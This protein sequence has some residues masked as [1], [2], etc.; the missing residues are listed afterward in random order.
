MIDIPDNVKQLFK[1]DSV[2]K[3]LRIHFPNGEH[4][5]INNDHI[6]QE[7]AKFTE[8]LCS[9]DS[10]KFGLCERSVFECDLHGIRDIKGSTIE[11]EIEIDVSSI[12]EYADDVFVLPNA[13]QTTYPWSRFNDPYD[14]TYVELQPRYAYT[15]YTP[16][17]ALYNI[18]NDMKYI[19]NPYTKSLYTLDNVYTYINPGTLKAGE[20]TMIYQQDEALMYRH[21]DSTSYRYQSY[22]ASELLP[23]ELYREHLSFLDRDIEVKSYNTGKDKYSYLAVKAT[24]KNE[25]GILTDEKY[26]MYYDNGIPLVNDKNQ[27][28][29][30]Q[31]GAL[32]FYNIKLNNVTSRE[33]ILA[34]ANI[35]KVKIYN[36]S[37]TYN[38]DDRYTFS[39]TYRCLGEVNT[40]VQTAYNYY[41]YNKY[42]Y[43][44]HA[45]LKSIGT[46]EPLLVTKNTC[47]NCSIYAETSGINVTSTLMIPMD[48]VDFVYEPVFE[49]E[50]LHN[51]S[52][53]N[54]IDTIVSDY[55][56]KE[57]G[58]LNPVASKNY[59]NSSSGLITY[60]GMFYAKFLDTNI[61]RR[62]NYT[63]TPGKNG[64][65]NI[66]TCQILSTN[67]GRDDLDYYDIDKVNL[68]IHPERKIYK[69][70][71]GSKFSNDLE[72]PYYPISYGR[73]KIEESE[74]D[75]S[76]KKR[77]ITAYTPDMVSEKVIPLERD[78]L[79][80]AT[81][82]KSSYI[83]NLIAFVCSQSY[84]D[85]EDLATFSQTYDFS[86]FTYVEKYKTYETRIYMS[87][88]TNNVWSDMRTEKYRFKLSYKPQSFDIPWIGSYTDPTTHVTTNTY[89]KNLRLK[90]RISGYKIDSTVSTGTQSQYLSL[91]RNH[92]YR[93]KTEPRALTSKFYKILDDIE[94]DA[95][96]IGDVIEKLAEIDGKTDT[97]YYGSDNLIR[98]AVF[99]R[100]VKNKIGTWDRL[101][102]EG[103]SNS[104]PFTRNGC[105][106][107]VNIKMSKGNSTSVVKGC[108]YPILYGSTYLF[109]NGKMNEKTW[110]EL[111]TPDIKNNTK[112][113]YICIPTKIEV[114]ISGYYVSRVIYNDS[115]YI[116]YWNNEEQILNESKWI[117]VFSVSTGLDDC[118]IDEFVITDEDDKKFVKKFDLPEKDEKPNYEE[119]ADIQK[120]AND[121]LELYGRFGH[122]D[123]SIGYY[124]AKYIEPE[125][126][127]EKL[128][129]DGGLYP[130]NW[131]PSYPMRG[132]HHFRKEEYSSI[133]LGD[134]IRPINAV[135]YTNHK[136]A[137]SESVESFD[138]KYPEIVS[139]NVDDTFTFLSIYDLKE[140]QNFDKLKQTGS[141]TSFKDPAKDLAIKVYKRIKD[142]GYKQVSLETMGRP[143]LE[144]GDIFTFEAIEEKLYNNTDLYPHTNGRNIGGNKYDKADWSSKEWKNLEHFIGY[145]VWTDGNNIYYSDGSSNYVLNK[146]NST[147]EAK[148]WNGLTNLNGNCIWTDGTNIY[149][150]YDTEQYVLDKSTSTW[151][152]KTWSGLTNFF[153]SD[154]WTDG[155]NI[156]YS[157]GSSQYVLNKSNSTWTTKTWN[158]YSSIYSNYIWTDG[159]DFYYSRGSN[160]Y[161]LN[162]NT[163]TWSTKVWT[164]ISSIYG[165]D[166]WNDG[167]NIYFSTSSEQYVL[168]KYTSTWT[169][170]IWTNL[171][172]P[173]ATYIWTDGTDFYY[174]YN[175]VQYV[176]NKRPD[177]E[178]VDPDLNEIE[179]DSV[180]YTSIVL[181]RTLSGIQHLR[182]S[183][184][185]K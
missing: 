126:F 148:T 123:R 114:F 168:D 47:K 162:R 143:Y 33:L 37:G 178:E 29:F 102:D 108:T 68:A 36:Q 8:S 43:T 34:Y 142:I 175:D 116:T 161:V 22:D 64:D 103:L 90:F 106:P 38:Y 52:L 92:I 25:Y 158:G 81:T 157:Y 146:T 104:K 50:V 115:G 166:I 100:C 127:T 91:D 129:P 177:E 21:L 125:Y 184:E 121:M 10:L 132:D 128:L 133:S 183:I 19:Y 83:P 179:I 164:G 87:N 40:S 73:F 109:G 120:L 144:S 2:K 180:G 181:R 151:T 131:G 117:P 32:L 86:R 84:I 58:I 150:S 65:T 139:N 54:K 5:D 149:Y 48:G 11:P 93:V 82:I 42:Y 70:P 1:R 45:Y 113:A 18:S 119:A 152:T 62:I 182:D 57:Y 44:R 122:W 101:M 176:Y 77:H 51:R 170:K 159:T 15:D 71:E 94:H 27:P 60:K 97:T 153:G 88:K 56:Y 154:I 46:E 118:R 163:D 35:L 59:E 172:D 107:F 111:A 75:D 13:Y 9:R 130:Y 28:T 72:Y 155:N 53:N 137:D 171:S 4:D 160:Q 174:S 165:T 63:I 134:D 20:S 39:V 112:Q 169:T 23:I 76:H 55:V 140:N 31:Y 185:S 95:E 147:W 105:Y 141:G 85:P 24:L 67:V 61:V 17:D 167:H 12:G 14:Y 173:I 124:E 99:C 6:I 135:E 49:E 98:K 16:Y 3:N 80:W 7:S 89:L 74:L 136:D 145:Y 69:Y 30:R 110:E 96:G 41:H 138:C 78:K 156:Y 79:E 26:E 66:Y